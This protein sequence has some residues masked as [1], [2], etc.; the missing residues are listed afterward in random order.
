MEIRVQR[1]RALARCADATGMGS[2]PLLAIWVKTASELRR[3]MAR[4][5]CTFEDGTKHTIIYF[6]GER[7]LM[8]ATQAVTS[9]RVRTAVS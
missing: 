2:S 9:R 1:D 4:L 5:G 3:N 6:K 8:P 7:T